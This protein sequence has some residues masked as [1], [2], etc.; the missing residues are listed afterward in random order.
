MQAKDT[1]YA[2]ESGVTR[3]VVIGPAGAAEAIRAGIARRGL[4]DQL[5][6]SRTA[7]RLTSAILADCS[8]ADAVVI[9]TARDQGFSA[10]TRR[11][12]VLAWG[13]GLPTLLAVAAST[14]ATAAATVGT[15]GAV[16]TAW[17]HR[18]DG[19]PSLACVA[20]TPDADDIVDA[21]LEQRVAAATHTSPLRVWIDRLDTSAGKS[22]ITGRV[23]AGTPIV[24]QKVAV[25]P[26]GASACIDTLDAATA[27]DGSHR[28]IRIALD[29]VIDLPASERA[30]LT[31]AQARPDLA[32]QVA[33]HLVWIGDHAMLPG[34]PYRARN[35][36]QTVPAQ[37]STIKHRLDPTE[38]APLAARQITEGE[39][40]FCNLSFSAP[41]LFDAP[42]HGGGLDLIEILEAEGDRPV[43]FARPQFALRR[44]TN[45][46]WQALS[47]DKTA[48][49]GI[50]HQK[51][52]CLWLTGL[53]GSGKSTVAS[54][55]EQRLVAMGRHTYT[56]D[57]DNVRHGLNRDLGFTE[58]DRVENIRRVAE[59]AR[60]F[61]DAGLI[62]ITSFISPFRAERDM[63]RSLLSPGEFL[64]IFVDTPLSVCE[65][66]DAKGLYRKARSGALKNFT[67]IDSPYEAPNRPEIT[68]KGDQRTPEQ[69]VET[70]LQDMA[71]RGIV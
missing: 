14:D 53:S 37:I 32:D 4:T 6:V 68:L 24:G 21:L 36:G 11:E 64:E 57:G 33:A 23:A 29:A 39:I 46:H 5:A 47:V 12:C 66:R 15:V 67:G 27:P 13:L 3:V 60:L 17:A 71:L 22:T 41:L 8:E 38:L 63:A 16:F 48:R 35:G 40:G 43:G 45:I 69:M 65:A 51:P 28:I 62:V 25:L 7:G 18:L 10:E 70:I 1:L 55:L 56:L 61:V 34:R 19:P 52:C 2:A 44:A 54:L 58:A 26:G 31:D 20:L 59:V 30:I 42:S 9:A 49:A 50:K